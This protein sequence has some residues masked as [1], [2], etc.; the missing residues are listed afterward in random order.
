MLPLFSLIL[1]TIVVSASSNA[2]EIANGTFE[3]SDAEGHPESWTLQ[4][5]GLSVDLDDSTPVEGDR[6]LKITDTGSAGSALIKQEFDL[7][8][9]GFDGAT[10]RG[11]IRTRGITTSA[12]LF[13]ILEGPE[14]RIYMDDMLDRVVRGDTEWRD[15]GVYIPASSEASFLSVGV[16]VIGKGTAWFDDL[17]LTQTQ[18][19]AAAGMD[20]REYIL[21]ALSIMRENYLH[22]DDVDWDQVRNRGL[23]SLSDDASM[24]QAHAAVRMMIKALND[25]HALFAGSKSSDSEAAQLEPFEYATVESAADRIALVR[26]PSV[27]GSTSAK[28][29]VAFA[30]NAHQALES[31]DSPELCGWIVDLR[32]NTGGTMWPMLAAIGP[33]AGPGV[34]GQF[35]GPGGNEVGTWRYRDGAALVAENSETIERAAIST[36]AFQ[37]ETPGL[38]V[39]VLVSERTASSGEATTIAFVGRENTRLFGSETGGLATANN[40][41]PLSDGVRI[42][43]PIAYM[44]DRH[45]NVHYPRI[46]PDE[47]VPAEDV[48]DAAINWLRTRISCNG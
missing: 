23:E 8:N 2:Q 35:I 45:G 4:V 29:Q 3:Q 15:Y 32:D 44:A 13:A 47:E 22:A 24:A 36:E 31:I 17:E 46:Q 26:I 40:G 33:I 21:E 5:R 42:I 25:P 27:P 30:H 48:E 41:Y 9:T 12:T 39:A 11:H 6:A 14:G 16:L 34:L 18:A 7:G 20:V 28:A 38:P 10:F 1:A 37:P 19:S 43:F